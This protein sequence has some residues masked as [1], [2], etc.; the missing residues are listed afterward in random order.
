MGAL[1][2]LQ[3]DEARTLAECEGVIGRGLETFL[4]VGNALFKIRD[5]R[6]YRPDMESLWIRA[7][8]T[9]IGDSQAWRRCKQSPC[10]GSAA[11]SR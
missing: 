1:L 4:E 8:R 7:Q 2:E 9:R 11:A 5:G 3:P 10:P 6:L